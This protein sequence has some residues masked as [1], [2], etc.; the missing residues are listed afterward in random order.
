MGIPSYYK[1]L[2]DKYPTL[3][4]RGGQSLLKSDILYMDFNCLIYYCLKA[5][6]PY[7]SEERSG[8]EAG[9]IEDVKRYTLVVWE[10][11]G[12]PGSVFIGVDGVVPMAKIRQQRLRRFKSVW[13]AAAERE[14]GAR[15]GE[16]WDSNAI[17][18]GT[19]F[20]EALSVGLR[21]LGRGWVISGAE[22]PGEGEQ[23]LMAA[24][25]SADLTGKAVAVYGLDAD[26]IV[27]SLKALVEQPVKSWHLLREGGEFGVVT[28]PFATLD[29]ALLLTTLVPRGQ[30]A[31][32]YVNDYICA[33]SFLGN[34]FLPHSLTVKI[35]DAGHDK[36]LVALRHVH[37]KGLRLVVGGQV[38]GEAAA[39]FISEWART[40]E[41]LLLHAIRHKYTMRPMVP[42]TDT[43]RLMSGVQNRP[44]EWRAEAGLVEGPVE[45]PTGLVSNWRSIYQRWLF[46]V[47]VEQ[48]A[49]EYVRGLQWIVDYYSGKPISYSWY[50]PWNVPPLWSDIRAALLKGEPVAPLRTLPIAPQEQLAMV[51]PLESWGLVRDK[52]LR[53]LPS[54]APAFW[55]SKFSFFSAGRRWIWECEAEIP[56]LCVERLR[57][58]PSLKPL[59]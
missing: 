30:V 8:W 27:L 18:P 25:R 43:E 33:M 53:A 42:R 22:E 48:A 2:I 28:H 19:A 51:L 47:P 7:K 11:A 6:P 52:G 45:K 39:E 16:S 14:A 54:V 20:M 10:A 50:Y 31:H 21:A 13:L 38:K 9:L 36:M 17:T 46:D 1:R 56:V 3:V 32:E 34:D 29:V 49:A 15:V 58:I 57:S 5:R 24:A 35:R 12:R 59:A 44:I 37:D 26:L 55:P 40:E 4:K 41:D 23:K